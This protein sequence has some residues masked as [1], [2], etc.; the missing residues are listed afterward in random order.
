M[1]FLNVPE[2][3]INQAC[4][5]WAEAKEAYRFFQNENVKESKILD[6][7]ISKTVE[8]I[9]N[10]ATPVLKDVIIWVA[11]LGGYLARKNDPEPG[12]I[13]IW[14]G[15]RHLVDLTQGWHMANSVNICG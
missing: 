2:S 7:H 8:R 12:P 4:G 1:D 3:S 14:R 9:K 15:W 10:H 11:R 6:L 13:V 5:S